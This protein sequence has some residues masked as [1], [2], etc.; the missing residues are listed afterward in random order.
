MLM[1]VGSLVGCSSEA[2][3]YEA[4]ALKQHADFEY[5]NYYASI[6]FD[7]FTEH[8]V[9]VSVVVTPERR[10][11]L[12]ESD[13]KC[14]YY[15]SGTEKTCVKKN[16]D[17]KPIDPIESVA[18]VDFAKY[19]FVKYLAESEQFVRQ[20]KYSDGERDVRRITG[21]NG[22]DTIELEY[23]FDNYSF[24]LGGDL[25]VMFFVKS[26]DS[27]LGEIVLATY[28]DQSSKGRDTISVEYYT[29]SSKLDSKYRT[30]ESVYNKFKAN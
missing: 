14:V 11:A 21:N 17:G 25:S 29:D 30:L 5:T 28:T 13:G 10:S 24:S 6:T 26:S 20:L 22:V 23:T 15:D 19:D 8:Q 9:I 27:T 12:I 1:I 16:G 3:D 4:I 7:A 18:E 2:D